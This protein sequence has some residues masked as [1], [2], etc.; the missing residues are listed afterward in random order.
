MLYTYVVFQ[1][2]L[3]HLGHCSCMTPCGL[4]PMYTEKR[5]PEHCVSGNHVTFDILILS[6]KLSRLDREPSRSSWSRGIELGKRKEGGHRVN[7]PCG[8]RTSKP[9]LFFSLLDKSM[10]LAAALLLLLM[11]HTASY[12]CSSFLHLHIYHMQSDG[13]GE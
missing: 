6:T 13:R 12:I 2:Q 1:V 9:L 4:L 10:V 11:W 3:E 8:S 5:T 7:G